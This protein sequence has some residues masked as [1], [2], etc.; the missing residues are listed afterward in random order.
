[1][2]EKRILRYVYPGSMI[3]RHKVW[4]ERGMD[5]EWC[6]QPADFYANWPSNGRGGPMTC[7]R[8]LCQ[9]HAEQWALANHVHIPDPAALP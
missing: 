5:K 6:R 3:C 4:G 2:S 1:M 8:P 7:T 9:H